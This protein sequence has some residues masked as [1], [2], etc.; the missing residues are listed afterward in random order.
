MSVKIAESANLL[1]GKVWLMKLD[2]SSND[3][4]RSPTILSR[5]VARS[6]FLHQLGR[7]YPEEHIPVL[8]LMQAVAQIM[9]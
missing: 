1:Q 2:Q 5:R 7:G 4:S 3:G 9:P 6:G 8:S